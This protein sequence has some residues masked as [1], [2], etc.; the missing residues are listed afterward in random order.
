MREGAQLC[1]HCGAEE[2]MH[3]P[4]FYDP[5]LDYLPPTVRD[6][7]TANHL[8]F[9]PIYAN[10]NSG[11]FTVPLEWVRFN[12][13]AKRLA[14]GRS[15]IGELEYIN[16]PLKLELAGHPPLD[17]TYLRSLAPRGLVWLSLTGV[18]VVVPGHPIPCQ[19]INLPTFIHTHNKLFVPPGEEALDPTLT[20][21]LSDFYMAWAA[22]A[23]NETIAY[24]KRLAAY[25]NIELRVAADGGADAEKARKRTM[26]PR[27]MPRLVRRAVEEACFSMPMLTGVPVSATSIETVPHH[28]EPL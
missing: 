6:Y 23:G 21:V 26:D 25:T 20:G 5:D 13:Q 18:R 4:D 24:A 10:A 19:L 22:R 12:P 11:D 28:F 7:L 8:S 1:K 16:P 15:S 27:E 9:S 17:I 14:R 3:Y 2:S